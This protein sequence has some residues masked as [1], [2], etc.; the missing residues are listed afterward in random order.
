MI[1]KIKAIGLALVAVLAMGAVLAGG[2]QAEPTTDEFTAQD[3]TYPEAFHGSNGVG[4]EKFITE[5][6]TV[7][8]A[9]TFTGE[10][11]EASQT[12]VVYPHYTS[13]RAFGFLS[14]TVNATPCDYLFHITTKTAEHTYDG[15]VDV[16]C[17]TGK[18]IT[19][20]ASTCEATVGPQNGLSN[21]HFRTTTGTPNDIDVTAEVT[22][23]AYTVTKDG[24]GCPFSGTGAKTGGKYE[25]VSPTTMTSS[26]GIDIG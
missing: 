16:T 23:I 15:T 14:A 21:V 25:S 18:T 17:E 5:A 19:I 12:V 2:A 4:Q 20:T 11:A 22:G 8:C 9:S 6:G 26:N 13:C 24:F 3:G 7:E 1:R 10:A